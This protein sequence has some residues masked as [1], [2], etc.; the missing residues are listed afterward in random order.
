MA[1]SAYTY[2]YA[3]LGELLAWIIG[4]DLVLEYA[5][6]SATVANG[7]SNYFIKFLSVFKDE[8][9]QALLPFRHGCLSDPVTAA[10]QYDD[11]RPCQD[12]LVVGLRQERYSRTILV[13]IRTRRRVAASLAPD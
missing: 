13:P 1:G 3:T 9:R 5:M 12:V 10:E 7:W 6:G 2:A 4:W 8:T 11:Y